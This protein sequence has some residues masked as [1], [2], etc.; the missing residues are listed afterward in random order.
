MCPSQ[1]ITT[2]TF[3]TLLSQCRQ[4]HALTRTRHSTSGRWR[5]LRVR[6]Y[7][8][9]RSEEPL[10]RRLRGRWISRQH[11]TQ[12]HW[13]HSLRRQRS[14]TTEVTR[15]GDDWHTGGFRLSRQNARSTQAMG[16]QPGYRRNRSQQ[17]PHARYLSKAGFHDRHYALP[18][19]D[20]RRKATIIHSHRLPTEHD[21]RSIDI[22]CLMTRS[23]RG[24]IQ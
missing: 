24:R 23:E 20:C 16:N 7:Q 21:S 22:Y 10:G 1:R 12:N 18:G 6:E 2:S 3:T 4:A 19:Y 11:K 17:P 9:N 5:K 8:T 14:R 15:F 13:K